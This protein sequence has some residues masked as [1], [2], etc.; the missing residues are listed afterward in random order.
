MEP[1]SSVF[2]ESVVTE[3]IEAVYS[4]FHSSVILSVAPPLPIV[5]VRSNRYS[6]NRG[7]IIESISQK[8]LDRKVELPEKNRDGSSWP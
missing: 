8:R 4:G 1:V 3:T 2:V 7:L 6:S 5:I